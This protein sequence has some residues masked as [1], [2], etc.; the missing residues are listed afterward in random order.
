MY[1]RLSETCVV[2]DADRPTKSMARTFQR[3]L[4]NISSTYLFH[5]DVEVYFR[6]IGHMDSAI[7][8][9]LWTE[10][11]QGPMDVKAIHALASLPKFQSLSIVRVRFNIP[12]DGKLAQRGLDH[13]S[14][15]L[16]LSSRAR[17]ILQPWQDRHILGVALSF[18]RCP[19][20]GREAA[21]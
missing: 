21:L 19:P 8:P 11:F 1:L 17:Y 9:S 12:D 7:V 14:L 20:S 18:F 13:G 4:S 5:L 10:D 3:L 16:D 15:A 2:V 6:R